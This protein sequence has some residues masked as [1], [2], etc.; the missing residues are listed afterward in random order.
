MNPLIRL[1]GIAGKFILLNIKALLLYLSKKN[2]SI[3]SLEINTI[4]FT[5]SLG[6]GTASYEKTHFYKN[7]YLIIRLISYRNDFY[8]SLIMNNKKY[9]ATQKQLF[10]FLLSNRKQLKKVIINSLCSYTNPEK[11][12]KFVINNFSNKEIIYLVHD[13]HCIC[14]NY[15]FIK[16][17]KYCEQRCDVCKKN[18]KIIKYWRAMWFSFFEKISVIEVFSNSSKEI[19]IKYYPEIIDKILVKPHDLSYCNFMPF[20]IN[21]ITGKNIGVIGNCSNA[22]KGKFVIKNLV[23]EIERRRNRKLIIIGKSPFFSP[24]KSDFFRVTGAYKMN[25][26]PSLIKKNEIGAI[27]FTSIWP[28]TFSYVISEIMRMNIPIVTIKLGAQGEKVANYTKGYFLESFEPNEICNF[29]DYFF[30]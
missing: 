12:L 22:A 2:T 7:N 25:E 29:F 9:I 5:H 6:G 19:L 21:D 28:E 13:Y 11:I 24:K 17:N 4:V 8:Y 18:Q 1:I 30:S 27:L 10:K 23:K 20:T 3:E 14:P 26:L 16:K 15:T